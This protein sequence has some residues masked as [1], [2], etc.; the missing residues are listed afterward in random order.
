[1]LAPFVFSFLFQ[2]NGAGLRIDVQ[3]HLLAILRGLGIK[4]IALLS[5]VSDVGV[6][7]GFYSGLDLIARQILRDRG[8]NRR[9]GETGDHELLDQKALHGFLLELWGRSLF[10][11]AP[12]PLS[13][14]L[15]TPA[16]AHASFGSGPR[17]RSA[18]YQPLAM[19]AGT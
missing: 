19:A 1:M 12:T 13:S 3:R 6:T 8:T 18:K 4:V 5:D 10:V 16:R 2:R 17:I 11:T 15:H 9:R 7:R 14:G